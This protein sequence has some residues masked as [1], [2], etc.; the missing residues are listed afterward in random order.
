MNKILV[1]SDSHGNNSNI[2]AVAI[3][4]KP[5][6]VIHAGD[7]C[8]DISDM[9]A[10]VDIIV[11]GNND[12]VG[13]KY[14]EI[15]VGG[16]R[17]GVTHGHKEISFSKEKTIE[18]FTKL[19]KKNKL[20]ILIF[21]HTHREFLHEFDGNFLLNPGSISYPRNASFLPSYVIIEIGDKKH[22]TIKIKYINNRGKWE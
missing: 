8:R 21:G 3:Q 19:I 4:E 20:D 14:K 15:E 1:V 11:A 13:N 7:Y 9:K 12:I 2:S 17:I 6:L 10:V 22:V 16:L 5:D 18:N